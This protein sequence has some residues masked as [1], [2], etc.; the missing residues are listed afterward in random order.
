MRL[1]HLKASLLGLTTHRFAVTSFV[2]EGRF[3]IVFFLLS[4]QGLEE[5]RLADLC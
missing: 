5:S 4:P 1:Q 3:V 2:F